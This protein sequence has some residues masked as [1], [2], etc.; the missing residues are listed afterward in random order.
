MGLY[1]I[2]T[3]GVPFWQDAGEKIYAVNARVSDIVWGPPMLLLLIGAGVYLSFLLG[4]FQLFRFG[5]WWKSTVSA[6]FRDKKVSKS[7]D[8]KAISQLQA[9]ATALASTLGTG[10]IV[11]VAT[12]IAAGG[13]GAIFWMW[14]SAFFGMMTNFAEKILGIYFRY[15]NEKGEWTGGAMIYIE[16]GLEMKWLAVLFSVFCALA[17]FGI[18]NIAQVNGIAVSMKSAFGVEHYVTGFFCALLVGL[19]IIGGLKRIAKVSEKL[20]PLMSFVYFAAALAVIGANLS[21]VPAAFADIFAGAF[22]LRSAGGGIA[23]YTVA[24]AARF[25][26]ARGVFSNEAGLGSSVIVH[27]SSD[28]KEPVAQGMWAIFEVF[29]DTIFICTLSAIAI[30]VTGANRVP[31]LEGAEIPFFAF[32]SVLG[33][34]GEYVLTVSILLFAFLSMIGWSFYGEKAVEYLGG[35]KVTSLYRLVFAA[36]VYFGAVSDVKLVWELSDTFNGLMAIPNLFALFALSGTVYKI[37]RNYRDRVFWGKSIPPLLSYGTE[38]K[39]ER[40]PDKTLPAHSKDSFT[41]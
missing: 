10:N 34:F 39:K 21:R 35:A 8:K 28:V 30:L 41:F 3:V 16:R 15:K 11:G 37:V 7:G 40:K 26:I 23:G 4:F 32:S 1:S 22:N 17:S 31:G 18:G 19:V 12:A 6:L 24:Q 29:F 36:A 14:V 2:L 13:P 25:G 9:L 27:S 5:H 38:Y 33:S 20:V